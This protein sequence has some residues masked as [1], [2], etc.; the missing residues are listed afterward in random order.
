MGYRV[1]RVHRT[2]EGKEAHMPWRMA[3]PNSWT[4]S[5]QRMI[6]GA[7]APSGSKT[8]WWKIQKYPERV[9]AKHL[10][11]LSSGKKNSLF[12]DGIAFSR[13][14]SE[15]QPAVVIRK[16]E[17]TTAVKYTHIKYYIIVGKSC[18]TWSKEENRE[19]AHS[20]WV[21]WMSERV[22]TED[23]IWM[24]T[25]LI[26][27]QKKK[28]TS[29]ICN[30]AAATPPPGFTLIWTIINSSEQT[31]QPWGYPFLGPSHHVR[32][33]LLHDAV[34]QSLA[35]RTCMLS[36]MYTRWWC[37]LCPCC[38]RRRE[39][40]PFLA[41]NIAAATTLMPVFGLYPIYYKQAKI[42]VPRNSCPSSYL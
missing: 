38:H 41:R 36:R 9:H 14:T 10:L 42:K 31:Q 24:K 26:E 3:D 35:S 5:P 11:H 25:R 15:I 28:A 7:I 6:C 21:I 2:G 12:D 33:H 19:G 39:G 32:T 8:R 29:E 4:S 1:A 18:I 13:S 20:C 37:A 17:K 22:P 34:W 23:Q 27:R 16:Q 30:I 40:M